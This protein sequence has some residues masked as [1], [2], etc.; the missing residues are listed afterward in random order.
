M[1]NP[2]T[3]DEIDDELFCDE[4]D[5]CD[6]VHADIDVLEG[7]GHC[8]MCGRSWYLTT[9]ELRAE[10]AYQAEYGQ[11]IED[12]MAAAEQQEKTA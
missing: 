12:E 3:Q 8:P 2:W 7:R 9:D 11:S 10:L 1:C 4:A 6:C 5:D